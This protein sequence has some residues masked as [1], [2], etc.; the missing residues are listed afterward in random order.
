VTCFTLLKKEKGKQGKQCVAAHRK[1]KEGTPFE[2]LV[3]H[4][5]LS[6]LSPPVSKNAFSCF[7]VGDG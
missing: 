7:S 3:G 2:L 4:F 5:R 6:R 1:K